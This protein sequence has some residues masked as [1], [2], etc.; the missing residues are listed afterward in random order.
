LLYQRDAVVKYDAGRP[1]HGGSVDITVLASSGYE[2]RFVV[3]E[4]VREVNRTQRWF[5]LHFCEVDWLPNDPD[6]TELEKIDGLHEV[7]E[8]KRR[9][10]RVIAVTQ[11]GL[12]PNWYV[13]ERRNSSVVT[14][15]D[16]EDGIA[17]PPLRVYLLYQIASALANF[18]ADLSDQQIKDW[19]HKPAV[20]CLFDWYVGVNQLKRCMVT[21]TLCAEH[22]AQLAGMGIQDGAVIA[23]DQILA[24]VRAGAT[25][26]P[27]VDASGVFVGHGRSDVWKE[28]ASFLADLGL[29]VHEFNSEP[30]AGQATSARLEELLSSCAF[31]VLVMTG[32]DYRLNRRGQ[33]GHYARQN[34][35]H[36]IGLFQ[37]RLGFGKAIVLKQRGVEEFSNIAGL[38]YIE[39]PLGGFR[40]ARK[41]MRELRD[42]LTREGMIESRARSAVSR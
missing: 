10:E 33:G 3:A 14:V 21:A 22:D 19:S 24:L 9:R 20:G 29:P 31:A 1:N 12:D 5:R 8:K 27:R 32:D 30:T 17:P 39:L 42:A 28:V 37:G 15:A 35:I 38:T 16:W 6:E 23:I 26:R 13:S 2:R 34:L 4:T 18:A 40:G 36:E 11:S 41:A 25:R 7:V